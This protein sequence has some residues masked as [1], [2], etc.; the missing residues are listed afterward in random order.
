MSYEYSYSIG[1][2]IFLGITMYFYFSHT[3]IHNFEDKFFTYLLCFSMIALVFDLLGAHGDQFAGMFPR[4]ALYLINIIGIGSLHV[5][6][7]CFCLYLYKANDEHKFI[8][9]WGYFAT[10]L[11]FFIDFCLLIISPISEHGIFFI[12]ANGLYQR[13]TTYNSLFFSSG[14]YYITS[15]VLVLVYYRD[16][17]RSRNRLILVCFVLFLASALLQYLFPRY[18]L[19]ASSTALVVSILHLTLQN[20]VDRVDPF[21]GCFSRALLPK[22]LSRY[23]EKG[24]SYTLLLFSV[25]LPNKQ[26]LSG[27]SESSAIMLRSVAAFL[28]ERFGR[29]IVVYMDSMQF[30]VICQRSVDPQEIRR[31][32]E[33]FAER[34]GKA[35]HTAP[36]EL[37]IAVLRSEERSDED[38]MLMTLDYLFKRLLGERQESV[39]VADADFRREC[40]EDTVLTSSISSLLS[41]ENTALMLNKLYDKTGHIAAYKALL[42]IDAEGIGKIYGD[43]LF[44]KADEAGL[45]W[46]YFSLLLNK[47]AEKRALLDDSLPAEI[48]IPTSICLTPNAADKI[49][50][51]V[52]TAGLNPELLVL[53]MKEKNVIDS[54][55]IVCENIRQTAERGYALRVTEFASDI[56]NI[57]LFISMPVGEIELSVNSSSIPSAGGQDRMLKAVIGL[58]KGLN[59]RVICSGVSDSRQAEILFGYG[60]DLIERV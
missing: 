9:K 20:P 55:E 18:L 24:I 27:M 10:F 45:G 28:K 7:P 42:A 54:Q 50:S 57:A 16:M 12:D 21:T 17:E 58:L 47:L 46:K 15:F 52:T 6:Q 40:Y 32:R 56:T 37:S 44:Q 19:N 41:A 36:P 51:L 14:I 2:I 31:A 38:T 11:P 59:K 48:A 29:D 5:C 39:L 35:A 34:F 43:R 13:G 23:K 30:T 3:R 8:K 4:W 22:L 25:S 60:A 33:S 1:S 26:N 49:N 53:S